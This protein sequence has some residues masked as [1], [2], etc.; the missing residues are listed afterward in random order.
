MAAAAPATIPDL[1]DPALDQPA[2]DGAVRSY[3]I[4][5][6][7]SAGGTLLA[8]ILVGVG[9]MG[10]PGHYFQGR[11]RVPALAARLGVRRGVNQIDIRAYV[12]ALLRHRTTP[13]GVFGTVLE[14]EQLRTVLAEEPVRALLR[15]SRFVWVRRRDRIG[16]ALAAILATAPPGRRAGGQAHAPTF[17]P[18]EIDHALGVIA[19]Q[20]RS[21]RLFF[22]QGG[23]A[24]LEIW[25]EDMLAD[26]ASACRSACALMGERPSR[27]IGLQDRFRGSRHERVVEDLRRRYVES[28]R[29]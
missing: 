10:V 24:P 21:W 25:H 13:N 12:A 6:T 16:Q 28:L 20:D 18:T 9:T 27:A 11:E 2:Y 4:A 29:W 1:S 17:L 7:P 3:V 8:R 22:E 26:P 5:G 19:A 14:F 23:F 15:R